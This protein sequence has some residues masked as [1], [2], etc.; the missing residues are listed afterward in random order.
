MKISSVHP[1]LVLI[2]PD[3]VAENRES[4]L[5]IPEVVKEK[6]KKKQNIGTVVMIGSNCLWA[7][8]GDVVSFYRH[9]FVELPAKEGE[10][11]MLAGHESHILCKFISD[12]KAAS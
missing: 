8:V 10:E 3:A 7:K 2:N 11:P 12:E 9:A 5:L 6:E 4:G 1:D